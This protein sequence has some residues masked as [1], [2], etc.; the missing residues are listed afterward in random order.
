MGQGELIRAVTLELSQVSPRDFDVKATVNYF[1]DRNFNTLIVFAVGY[2]YGEAYFPSA[3]MTPHE[4]LDG[5]DLFGEILA[6]AKTRNL[7]VF[8]YVN[9]F[10]GGSQHFEAH[11]DWTARWADGRE[12]TQ[13]RAKGMCLNSPYRDVIAQV[14]AEVCARYEI[15]GLY[16]DEPSLQSWCACDYCKA[17]YRHASGRELPLSAEG[18]RGEFAAFLDWRSSCVSEFVGEVGVAC[19]LARPT[20]TFFAQHAFPLSSTSHA[21]H[22]HL[23]WGT[24]S[25]RTPP[26]FED[27]YR[28]SFYGQDIRRVGEHLDMI[29]IEPWRRFAGYAS[30]WQ[31]ACVNYARAAGRNK[32]VLPLMEYPHFPWG[33]GRLSDDELHVNCADV[34]ANGGDLWWPMYAPGAADKGGWDALS[35]VFDELAKMRPGQSTI[36][37]EAVIVVS[38]N[39][40]ERYALGNVDELYLDDLLGTIQIVR[41]LHVPYKL[42]VEENLT[43]EDLAG[44][45]VVIAPSAACLSPH[46]ARFVNEYVRQGGVFIAQGFVGTHDER[47]IVRETQLLEQLLGARLGPERL[48]SRLGYLIDRSDPTKRVLVRD[49]FPAMGVDSAEVLYDIA[50]SRDLFVPPSLSDLSP[51]FLRK[52]V[53]KG[54]AYTV[55]PALGRLRLRYELFEATTFYRSLLSSIRWNVHGIDVGSQVGLHAWRNGSEH[56]VMLVNHQGISESGCL[57]KVSNQVVMIAG[58]VRATSVRGSKLDVRQTTSGLRV[59]VQELTHWDCIVAS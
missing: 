41:E 20:I 11:P 31:G 25:G 58:A 49:E 27:W 22:K 35:G 54:V 32:P 57:T 33:L 10:F 18:D 43:A 56:H 37:A 34:V 59:T 5:R 24:T 2:L 55:G 28:P 46:A 16:L 38:R 6:E 8:A 23:F 44:V 21:L 39:S 12:T 1:A 15:D 36:A 3:I 45:N 48:H 53:G 4:E 42:L 17:K 29:G 40:A 26:Q 47:G 51:G 13:V 9:S 7:R 19:R 50:P 30:W 14:S 52:Q